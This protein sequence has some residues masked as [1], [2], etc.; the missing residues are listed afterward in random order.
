[1]DSNVAYIKNTENRKLP[2]YINCCGYEK[3][4]SSDNRICRTHGRSDY[5]LLYTPKGRVYTS[6]S[7]KETIHPSGTIL[8]YRPGQPQVYEYKVKDNP[9]SLFIHFSGED[10]EKLLK[11][12]SINQQSVFHIPSNDELKTMFFRLIEECQS[13]RHLHLESASLMLQNIFL[14]VGRNALKP[15][16]TDSADNCS[17]HEF[18]SDITNAINY[19]HK[20]YNEKINIKDYARTLG[21]SA[22]WFIAIFKKYTYLT[23]VQFILTIKISK[24]K[25]LLEST[26]LSIAEVASRV[27]YSDPMYFSRQFKQHT[28]ISPLEYRKTNW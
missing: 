11:I 4:F 25:S 14:Y 12:Y 2:V 23:P 22:N 19:F 6:E 3:G 8:L 24:A 17:E 27:G 9:E 20:H 1:M 26:T 21:I 7:N 16:V 18:H 10:V 5:L 28:G 15:S 13:G